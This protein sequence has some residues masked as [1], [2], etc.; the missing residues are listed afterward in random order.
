MAAEPEDEPIQ[1]P[2]EA[3]HLPD[4]SYIPVIVAAGVT[5]AVVGVVLNPVVF[6]I[7]LIVTVVAVWRW[8]RDTR[9]DIS[10]LPL[11]H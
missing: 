11:E 2:S 3:I 1:E 4:P 7:G 5:I 9:R 6:A 8:V 10:E